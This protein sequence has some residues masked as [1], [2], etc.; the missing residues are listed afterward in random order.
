[1]MKINI[2]DIVLKKIKNDINI[3]H[4]FNR[5]NQIIINKTVKL[6]NLMIYEQLKK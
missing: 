2:K 4:K 5:N 6:V 1:M 3:L